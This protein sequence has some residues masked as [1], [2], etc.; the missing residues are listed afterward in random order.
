MTV[1]TA[2]CSC[3]KLKAVCAGEPSRV[4]LCHCME[5]QKR[6]GSVFGV[7]AFFH[8]EKV[9]TQGEFKSFTRGSDSGQPITFHFCPHCGTTLFWEPARKPETI[10]VAVGGF[11][12]A[13]FPPPSREVYVE[14][15][16]PWVRNAI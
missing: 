10:A 15:R 9:E 6:T 12:D 16:H 2:A 7:A 14:L 3:G 5:C 1:R 11:A 8:R 4:S 13:N